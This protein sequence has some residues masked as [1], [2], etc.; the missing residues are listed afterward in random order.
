MLILVKLRGF[1]VVMSRNVFAFPLTCAD[2]CPYDLVQTC[3]LFFDLDLAPMEATLKA[4][5]TPLNNIT[6]TLQEGVKLCD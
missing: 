2:A 5:I 3:D 1:G 4:A 6:D